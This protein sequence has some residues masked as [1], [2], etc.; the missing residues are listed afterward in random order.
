MGLKLPGA[1]QIGIL[2]AKESLREALSQAKTQ[3]AQMVMCIVAEKSE[4]IYGFVHVS[5]LRTLNL[6]IFRRS[7]VF[8]R[9]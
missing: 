6:F 7:E 9:Y 4:N 5:I 2:A 1:G 3:K 8:I